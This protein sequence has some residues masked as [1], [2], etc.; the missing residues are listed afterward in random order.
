MA[1]PRKKLPDR[2]VDVFCSQCR[3]KLLQ[4]K[5]GGTGSLVKCFVERITK[6]YTQQLGVCPNCN[7]QFARETIIRGV[8][9]LKIVGGKVSVK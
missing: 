1:K 6:D 7:S 4:Y 8:P 2:S 3:T 5:T 9:A